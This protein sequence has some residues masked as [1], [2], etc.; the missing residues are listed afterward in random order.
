LPAPAARGAP[1]PHRR[2]HR[3]SAG[4]ARIDRYDVYGTT[5]ASDYPFATP[6]AG[7]GSGPTDVVFS[8]ATTPTPGLG[9]E[10]AEPIGGPSADAAADEAFVF[11]RLQQHVAVRI[12]GAAD[13]HTLDDRIVGHLHEERHRYLVEIALFGMV[14]ALWHERRGTLALHG[15][16]ASLDGR[17]VAF[18]GDKGAGKT[19]VAA[20][21]VAAG[22][23]FLTDDLLVV[24]H[25][26]EVVA[27]RAIPAIR[28][29]PEGVR[30]F[31]GADPGDFPA[32][33]PDFDKRRVPIQGS[34]L[35][36]F[37]PGPARLERI[38]VLQRDA[39]RSREVSIDD[40]E[41]PDAVM[42]LVRNSYLPGEVAGFGW[43]GPRLAALARL[44][45]D[46][47]V[48]IL[49]YGSDLGRLGDVVAAVEDDLG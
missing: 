48:R 40:L 12:V 8:C 18:L 24:E 13:F 2:R 19:S 46:V 39:S 7:A 10:A 4:S 5:M 14:F 9:F 16:A 35:G 23:G 43:H 15:S 20:A 36:S 33:H 1:R 31:V 17:G 6:L 34:G 38:Y 3:L 28:L 49:R 25:G 30:H 37:A 32:P 44:A 27:H 47:R 45:G 11:A 41:G 21:H 29:W 42:A 22:H 26:E